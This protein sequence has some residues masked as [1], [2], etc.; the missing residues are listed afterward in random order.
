MKSFYEESRDCK[1]SVRRSQVAH[2]L[3]NLSP[4]SGILRDLCMLC[5]V[6]KK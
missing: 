2:N 5:N 1:N 4:V 6:K 3:Q